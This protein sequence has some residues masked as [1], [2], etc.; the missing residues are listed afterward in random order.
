MF[1]AIHG[2]APDIA[3]KNIANPCGLLNASV[4][5]LNYLGLHG[6]ATTIHNAILKTIEDGV[7]TRDIAGPYTAIHAGTKE[8]TAEVIARLGDKPSKLPAV[9]Y[10]TQHSN[11]GTL[12]RKNVQGPS[13]TVPETPL[14]P[15]P[16]KEFVGVDIFVDW[17]PPSGR[18]PDELAKT[19]QQ[20][21]GSDFKLL[22]ISNRGVVVW[23]SGHPNTYKVDHWRCRYMETVSQG[24]GPKGVIGLMGRLATQG[25]EVIKTENLY[26]FDGQAGY[27]KG[28]GQ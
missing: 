5:M 22:M 14:R 4:M 23:P 21:C 17:D 6:H 19:L 27:S 3:G 9:D 12:Q 11:E 28:Q 8:F 7:H 26:N 20:A 13:F 25:I 18:N 10:A 2:S 1:E 24:N 16:K 15:S